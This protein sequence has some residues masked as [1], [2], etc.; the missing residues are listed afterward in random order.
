MFFLHL[1]NA[2]GGADEAH[3]PDVF[4]AALLEHREGVAGAA[5][6]GEHRVGDDDRALLDVFRKLAVI[7]DRFVRLLIA[8]QAD[9]AHLGDGDEHLQAFDHAHAGSQDRDD[10]ELVSGDSLR[11]HLAD[12]R[13]DFHALQRDV[14]GDLVTHQEGD[15]L[16]KF[17]EILGS[18]FLHAHDGQLVL[19]HRV[20]DNMQL[21]HSFGYL[22]IRFLKVSK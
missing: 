13:F 5:A 9:V 12:G 17:P 16:E 14:A 20:V 4:A 10:G 7:D 1:G 6:G 8:V 21:A 2:F 11:R 19:D 3:Q 15:F 22:L 18:G